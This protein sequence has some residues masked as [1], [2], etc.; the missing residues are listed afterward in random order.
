M[1]L[2]VLPPKWIHS[3]KIER[4]EPEKQPFEAEN[5]LNQAFGFP[6]VNYDGCKK[7]GV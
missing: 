4:L 2:Q 7:M 6:N 1:I 5:H 3:L